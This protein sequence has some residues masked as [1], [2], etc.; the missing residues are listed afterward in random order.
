MESVNLVHLLHTIHCEK[1]DK[2]DL[3]SIN[4]VLD[5]LGG[6]LKIHVGS[7]CESHC[8]CGCSKASVLQNWEFCN[9]DALELKFQRDPSVLCSM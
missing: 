6:F 3:K 7:F 5:T 8:I 4:A 2:T 9:T 1:K